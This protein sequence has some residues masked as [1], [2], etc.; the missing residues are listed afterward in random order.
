MIYSVYGLALSTNLPLPGMVS[1][2]S[3]E[4]AS[5]TVSLGFIPP[6]LR[7]VAGFP[8][9]IWYTNSNTDDCGQP[10][11]RVWKVANGSYFRLLYCDGTQFL[12]DQ[13]GSHVWATWPESLTLE[14]TTTYLVGPV[15]GFVLRLRGITCLHASAIA[16]S[17]RA[18]AFLGPAGAGKSTT[19]AGFAELGFPVLSDDVIALDDRGD[20]FLVQSAYPRLRL[21]PDSVLSL[22]GSREALPKITPSWD[23]RFLDLT[24]ERYRF[25]QHPLRLAVI[26]VLSERSSN[27][28]SPFIEE[29]DIQSALITLIANTYTNYLLDKSR[30]AGEF[31][32][33]DRVIRNVPL[34]KLTARSGSTDIS[35]LCEVI[36]K[37]FQLLETQLPR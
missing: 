8:E 34:R 22:Y 4:P 3:D 24:G 6:M 20:S 18:I 26:Y 25:H 15:L 36:V 1:L 14:D 27:S 35:T 17:D 12:V 19:A 28:A 11:L 10:I 32:L 30:R 31:E 16:V 13:C 29:L 21:W 7:D 2:P 23:K 33:L 9:E 5:V 37:D